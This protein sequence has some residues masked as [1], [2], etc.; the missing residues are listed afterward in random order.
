[1]AAAFCATLGVTVGAVAVF[2]AP[3]KGLSIALAASSRM[4][5][6][7]FWP[8][9]AGGAL[10]V[11][12]GEVFLPLARRGRDLGLAFAGALSVHL[13]VVAAIC[14]IGA[15]PPLRTF[16]I[17]G[18]GA[19]FAVLLTLLSI[20]KVRRLLPATYWPR[21]RFVAMTYI[22]AAFLLDFAKFPIQ[23]IAQA[24]KYLPFTTLAV[25]GPALKLA[26]WAKTFRAT[27][28][29]QPPRERERAQPRSIY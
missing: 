27:P 17:F 18:V 11:L 4:A 26:A 13:A 22:A 24:A 21:L 10:C 1:M 12:F 2:Y 3:H 25:L 23:D 14:A 15:P 19:L 9:Y 29:Y 5:F 8:A 20:A 7:F 28:S 16:V 6:V